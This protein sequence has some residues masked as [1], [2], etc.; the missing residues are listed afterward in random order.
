MKLSRKIITIISLLLPL[1]ISAQ[2][3]E[4][5][6][7]QFQAGTPARA[8]D[9]NQTIQALITTI[10]NNN[11]E[12]KALRDQL[13]LVPSKVNLAQPTL[14]QNL[15][16]SVYHLGILEAAHGTKT[17]TDGAQQTT[18]LMR[19]ALFGET[20]TL[21]LNAD[22]TL[23]LG[24]TGAMRELDL[25][26][27]SGVNTPSYGTTSQFGAPE[28]E[29]LT[30]TWSLAGS[31]LTLNL[32]GDTETFSV[33]VDGNTLINNGSDTENDDPSITMHTVSMDVGVRISK[34]QPNIEVVV[35][36]GPGVLVFT[37]INNGVSEG[38]ND[39]NA[40]HIVIKNT[41]TGNLV[42]GSSAMIQET[43]GDFTFTKQ[44]G[45]VTIAPN[46]E[47]RMLELVNPL[48]Q[49]GTRRDAAI[50]LMTNDPDT[51][52]FIVNVHSTNNP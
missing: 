7:I 10:N 28:T 36:S 27:L 8:A 42:L 49:G 40:K 30:G 50:Y 12:I 32:D 23:T 9:M 1:G 43:G 44:T 16:G 18:R 14:Q 25:I 17:T 33:S 31:V 26:L 48:S 5:Q 20:G 13:T 15:A 21:T 38:V 41:G 34:P 22:S 11:A 46:T 6:I 47:Y 29:N 35:E 3:D 51:P 2:V 37:P 45:S 19:H 4:S 39:T 24:L 52:T